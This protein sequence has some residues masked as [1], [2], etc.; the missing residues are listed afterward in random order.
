MGK[1]VIIAGKEPPHW[2]VDLSKTIKQIEKDIKEECEEI[3]NGG[4]TE[5]VMVELYND[6]EDLKALKEMMKIPFDVVIINQLD[7]NDKD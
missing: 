4:R 6:R 2:I 1:V 7:Q 3:N 5:E